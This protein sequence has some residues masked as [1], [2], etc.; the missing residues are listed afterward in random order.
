LGQKIEKQLNFEHEKKGAE[1]IIIIVIKI[2]VLFLPQAKVT[3]ADFGY[4]V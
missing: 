4:P 3:L 1:N 2:K